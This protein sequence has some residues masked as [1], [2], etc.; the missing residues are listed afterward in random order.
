MLARAG[1][2]MK[3]YLVGLAVA[4]LSTL[5]L[6]GTTISRFSVTVQLKRVETCLSASLSESTGALVQVVCHS[7]NFVSIEPQPGTSFVGTHGGAY[8]YFFNV[9]SGAVAQLPPLEDVAAIAEL[10]A[11]YGTVT[12]LHVSDTTAAAGDDPGVLIVY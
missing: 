4:G 9:A 6:A 10:Y 12:G 2:M 11:G 3:K 7:G 8:R 5:C 1:A